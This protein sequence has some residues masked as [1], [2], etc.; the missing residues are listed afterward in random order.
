MK[1]MSGVVA[2]CWCDYD[3]QLQAAQCLEEGH[4]LTMEEEKICREW[5]YNTH[6]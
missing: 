6:I 1:W 3:V 4:Q 5:W 2:I